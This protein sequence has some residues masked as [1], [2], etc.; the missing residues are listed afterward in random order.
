MPRS[1]SEFKAVLAPWGASRY[2]FSRAAA[3]ESCVPQRLSSVCPGFGPQAEQRQLCVPIEPLL[4]QAALKWRKGADGSS[5]DDAYVMYKPEALACSQKFARFVYVDLG[6]EHYPSSVGGWFKRRYPNH[7]AFEVIA[8]EADPYKNGVHADPTGWLTRHR[9]VQMLPFGVWT[10]NSTTEFISEGFGAHLT[11]EQHLLSKVADLAGKQSGQA[12]GGGGGAA[13]NKPPGENVLCAG[14]R[15]WLNQYS[16][17]R[18]HKRLVRV[19]T[20][21]LA[22]FLRRRVT[23]DDFVVVKLDCE[24]AEYAL[25]PHLIASGVAP[26]IDEFF[27]EVHAPPPGGGQPAEQFAKRMPLAAG[28]SEQS[29]VELVA[30]ARKAG[31]YAH[32][33]V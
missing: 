16:D 20:L 8:F 29:A 17:P 1:G 19:Q 26:L 5:L 3:H 23:E 13:A 28:Q 2:N 4:P 11:G 14:P 9:D 10:H 22:E 12:G 25:V 7:A 27:V 31:M 32:Q 33:W 24:G 18:Q 21:D 30:A 15:C 6:A